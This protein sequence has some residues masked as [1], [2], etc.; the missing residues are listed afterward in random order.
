M[1]AP[2][3]DHSLCSSGTDTLVLFGGFVAGTR[4]NDVYVGE[5]DF[6]S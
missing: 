2:R 5:I 4:T 1:P 6:H 3:D